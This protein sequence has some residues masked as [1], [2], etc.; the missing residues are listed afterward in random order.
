MRRNQHSLSGL[1]AAFLFVAAMMLPASVWAQSVTPEQPAAGDGTLANPYQIANAAQLAWF[2]DWVNGTYTPAAGE[3]ATKHASACAKLTA[4]IDMSTVCSEA[5]GSWEPISR[6]DLIDA[7]YEAWSGTFDGDGHTLS[8]LYVNMTIEGTGM[9]GMIGNCTIKNMT[10]SRVN[11]TGTNYY[12]GIIG[13]MI[14][15]SVTNVTVRD[16]VISGGFAVGGICGVQESS[17]VSHC[18]NHAQVTGRLNVGGICGVSEGTIEYCT[19]YGAV[20]GTGDNNGSIGGIGGGAQ[21]G[22]NISHSANYGNV[23]GNREVGGILGCFY[24]TAYSLANVM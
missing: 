13:Y 14:N 5:I 7:V 17:T 12:T 8:N 4:D 23:E 22:G 11:I 1:L 19:N 20:K 24:R 6:R 21:S 15:G 9:F 10:F 16:G 3:T 2:R 18:T